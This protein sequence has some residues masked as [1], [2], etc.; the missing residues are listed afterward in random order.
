MTTAG[1]VR[2]GRLMPGQSKS[3]EQIHQRERNGRSTGSSKPARRAVLDLA[4]PSTPANS[5]L[6][7]I[8]MWFIREQGNWRPSRTW[9]TLLGAL[10]IPAP[11]ARTALHRMTK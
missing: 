1:Y 8:C 3:G 11:T 7:D 2:I 10:D 5:F 6:T 4:I 9:V